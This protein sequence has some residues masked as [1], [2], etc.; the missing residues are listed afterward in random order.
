MEGNKA[1]ADRYKAEAETAKDKFTQ[2]AKIKKEKQ[3]AIDEQKKAE[4]A[5]ANK[6]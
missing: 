3:D 6:Q 1:D 4:E 2:L 5:A